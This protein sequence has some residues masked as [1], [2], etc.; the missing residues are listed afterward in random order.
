MSNQK[1]RNDIWG[2][3]NG[4]TYVGTDGHHH[5]FRKGLKEGDVYTGTDGH[6]HH[7]HDVAS[8]HLHVFSLRNLHRIFN[9]Y[10]H[11]GKYENHSERH[12]GLIEGQLYI[13]SDG[14][15]HHYHNSQKTIDASEVFKNNSLNRYRRNKLMI[16]SLY[17]SL[18]ILAIIIILLMLYV[19]SVE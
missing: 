12:K 11:M 13:G 10:N 2:L 3:K 9:K 17:Y 5:H 15:H 4:D 18:N 6:H 14:H 8:V 16:K 7:Y 19:Y 1:N